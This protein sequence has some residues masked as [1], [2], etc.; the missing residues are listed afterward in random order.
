MTEYGVTSATQPATAGFINLLSANLGVTPGAGA[1]LNVGLPVWQV[2]QNFMESSK[3]IASLDTPT[4]NFQ[5]LLLAGETPSGS[6]LTLP[7]TSGASL[8]LTT[9]TDTPTEGFLTGH[10]ATAINAGA[11]FSALPGANSLGLSNTL[12]AGDDLVATGAAIGNSTL[13]DTAVHSQF[14]NP[15]F[16]PGVTMTGVSTAVITNLDNTENAGFSGTITGL[17]TATLAAGSVGGVTLGGAGAGLNTALTNVN[18][19]ASQNFTAIMTAAAFAGAT[20]PTG[21]VTLDGPVNTDG[22]PQC[23]WLHHW[24]L[25]ADGEQRRSGGRR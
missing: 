14:G 11:V 3:V 19:N 17:T 4:A 7:G 22:R 18:I 20:A 5:N 15:S 6:I 10:G 24:L 8:T 16:A 13:N 1:M 25:G 2:L 23:G 9:G 12:N 21:A